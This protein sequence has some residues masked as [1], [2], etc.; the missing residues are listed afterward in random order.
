MADDIYAH[1]RDSALIPLMFKVDARA[2]FLVILA[3]FHA[4]FYTVGAVIIAVIFLSI[5]N[6]YNISLMACIRLTRTFLGGSRK[7]IIRRR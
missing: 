2:F 5:L 4:T 6:Y 1:W 3:L 7:I